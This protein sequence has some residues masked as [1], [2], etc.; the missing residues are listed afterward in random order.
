MNPASQ[1][2]PGGREAPRSA[3]EADSKNKHKNKNKHKHT[4]NT[5]M[6]AEDA[7]TAESGSTGPG[8]ATQGAIKQTSKTKAERDGKR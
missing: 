1:S 4:P 2:R 8:A 5:D 7:G 6:Q 3:K